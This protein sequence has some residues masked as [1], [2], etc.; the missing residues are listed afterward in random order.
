MRGERSLATAVR[1]PDGNIV[2]ESKRLE[3]KTPWWRKIP[4]LR[5]AVNFFVMLFEGMSILMRSAEVFGEEEPS[6]FEKK[7]AKKFK[8]SLFDLAIWIG[9]ALGLAMSVFLFIMLPQF[10][11]SGIEALFSWNATPFLKNL[12]MG[13]IRMLI[14][15]F[16]ILLTA[17]M[18]D[19]KRVYMYHGA[20]HKTISCYESG[21]ELTV[22]NVRP[23]KKEHDRCGTT[24]MFLVMAVSIVFFSLLGLLGLDGNMWTRIGLRLLLM[25][26]VA[27][28]SYEILKG[29]AKFDNGLVRI[30][31]APGVF[32]QKFTTKEPDDDMIEV[33]IKAFETARAMDEDQSLPTVS[34]NIDKNFTLAMT[35]IQNKLRKNKNCDAIADSEWIVSEVL[36]IS[37]SEVKTLTT[38]KEDDLKKVKEMAERRAK[39]EPLQYIFGEQKFLDADIKCDKRAL[40]PRFETEFMVDLAIREMTG[41]EKVLDMCTGT[42][43]IAVSIKKAK[44]DATVTAVDFYEE[45]LSLARENGEK[46]GVEIEFVQ[47]DMFQ[48]VKGEYDVILSN[49]PYITQKEMKKLSKEVLSEPQTAL[50]GGVDGLDFYKIIANDS[51]NFVKYGGVVYL[52]VGKGQADS[53]KT[54]MEK[55]FSEVK[56]IR[57]L[58]GVD[59]IVKARK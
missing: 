7:M 55:N 9:V 22:E 31:K 25:P 19:V 21:K 3:S 34:F 45:A 28:I 47:S 13:V 46:N 44:Q 23:C 36:G 6:E 27:G 54:L 16:Y 14:F 10:I 38:I 52:E 32:L 11:L 43:A 48:N 17:L 15:L 39:G 5:G 30:M 26:V 24:F 50:Y 35:D 57:D 58:D 59:R 42:G 40:I 56:I 41:G 12:I 2:V 8:V 33:A 4:I 20:E 1:H 18:K 37:R 49:P 51:I 29:L 53:V